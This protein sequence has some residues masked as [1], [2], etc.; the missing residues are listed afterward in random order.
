MTPQELYDNLV[1]D[2][3]K[4]IIEGIFASY[5]QGQLNAQM[6]KSPIWKSIKDEDWQLQYIW[7]VQAFLDHGITDLGI[8]NALSNLR[9]VLIWEEQ[10]IYSEEMFF[11]YCK[12]HGIAVE[13]KLDNDAQTLLKEAK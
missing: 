6:A 4:Q 13:K 9:P 8:I 3:Q 1:R 10:E 5:S 12:K 7:P 11:H 2:T